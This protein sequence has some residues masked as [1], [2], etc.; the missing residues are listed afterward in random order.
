MSCKDF[1]KYSPRIQRSLWKFDTFS[2]N[3]LRQYKIKIINIYYFQITFS[4]HGGGMHMTFAHVGIWV[5]GAGGRVSLAA[6]TN[7][8]YEQCALIGC[9]S[10]LAPFRSVSFRFVLFAGIALDLTSRASRPP[11]SHLHL[12]APL[13]PVSPTLTAKVP[14]P[15][16]ICEF[17]AKS[18]LGSAW[19]C[20]ADVEFCWIAKACGGG[21]GDLEC[22]D[23][24]Y[25]II[26]RG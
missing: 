3:I 12:H 18:C 23:G 14:A 22:S 15:F 7:V 1:S 4:V 13:N 20:V 11:I 5:A 6:M 10:M 16:A 2:F 8:A 24:T 9:H 25:C 26:S 19:D 21:G 17:R